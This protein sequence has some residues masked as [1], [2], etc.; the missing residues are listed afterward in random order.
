MSDWITVTKRKKKSKK[1]N[2][3]KCEIPKRISTNGPKYGQKSKIDPSKLINVE[4]SEGDQWTSLYRLSE[5]SN[6]IN[7]NIIDLGKWTEGSSTW[8]PEVPLGNAQYVYYTGESWEQGDQFEIFVECQET[9]TNN[10]LFLDI[11]QYHI[12]I[13]FNK[14]YPLK[15]HP[16]LNKLDHLNKWLSYAYEHYILY[17]MFSMWNNSEQPLPKRTLIIRHNIHEHFSKQDIDTIKNTSKKY[18]RDYYDNLWPKK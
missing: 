9:L 18:R 8:S 12:N 13:T 16:R 11:F 4:M 10:N 2:H 5:D 15:L 7:G 17:D 1:E 3:I 6:N 14:K